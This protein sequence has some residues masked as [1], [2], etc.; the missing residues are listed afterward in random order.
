MLL[1]DS[2]PIPRAG[3]WSRHRMIERFGS[4][5][6]KACK[7]WRFLPDTPDRVAGCA[8]TPKTSR[9]VSYA[10]DRTLRVWEQSGSSFAPAAILQGH[11]DDITCVVIEPQTER[12][13]SGSRDGT[14]RI[15]DTSTG[16]ELHVLEGHSDWVTDL[17]I[18]EDG[19]WIV[20]VSEDET[21]KLWDTDTG[22]CHGTVVGV[23][24]FVSVMVVGGVV[25]AGDQAGNI[26]RLEYGEAA[27]TPFTSVSKIGTS[28]HLGRSS[29][30]R[31][32][33]QRTS[34]SSQTRRDHHNPRPGQDDRGVA[35][36]LPGGEA[37]VTLVLATE[38]ML[39]V[40]DAHPLDQAMRRAAAGRLLIPIWENLDAWRH[41]ELMNYQGIVLKAEGTTRF[42]EVAHQLRT[43]LILADRPA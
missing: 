29:A 38:R 22:V 2:R 35:T 21:V 37:D 28:D 20:S 15:W 11:R 12:T 30:G 26:W 1:P 18:S 32:A 13:I 14:I 10:A 4:G 31:A 33:A 42:L 40:E 16:R 43:T 17:S 39:A 41:S 8:V 27:R 34:G 23:C 3:C 36:E 9:V 5:T 24:P 6:A 25:C 7:P 19:R